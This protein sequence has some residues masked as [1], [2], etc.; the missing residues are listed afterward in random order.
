MEAGK[1]EQC[2]AREKRRPKEVGESWRSRVL[3]LAFSQAW[4]ND[5]EIEQARKAPPPAQEEPKDQLQAHHARDPPP[6]TD[7]RSQ[8][9]KR[10]DGLIDPRGTGIDDITIPVRVSRPGR[11]VFHY[12]HGL[13]ST[14]ARA[15]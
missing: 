8:A 6:A 5:L 15:R 12:C 9:G 13:F 11:G 14:T 4:L 1:V 10:D 2:G 3:N 7:Q